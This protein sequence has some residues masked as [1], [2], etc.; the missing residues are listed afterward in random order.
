MEKGLSY[1]L[2]VAELVQE[3]LNR[4]NL[5]ID[6]SQ[7]KVRHRP[8]Y[9]SRDRKKD[10]IFDVS[11]EVTR[12]GA[13]DPVLVQRLNRIKSLR[14]LEGHSMHKVSEVDPILWTTKPPKGMKLLCLHQV[15]P[16]CKCTSAGVRYD[17]L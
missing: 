13:S 16:T 1:E 9:Y 3:E 15:S 14:P 7:A 17:R 10:I 2:E 11:V 5:G 12:K 8:N 6:P 4:G